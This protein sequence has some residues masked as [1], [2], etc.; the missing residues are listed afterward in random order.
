MRAHQALQ[1]GAVYRWIVKIQPPGSVST[2]GTPGSI[3]RI[4]CSAAS[5]IRRSVAMGGQREH[6]LTGVV[7]MAV[8]HLHHFSHLR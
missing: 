1:L 6:K 5:V 7:D 3:S 4:A 2:R 8:L